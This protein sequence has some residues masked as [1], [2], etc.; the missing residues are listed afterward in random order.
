MCSQGGF[1]YH[2]GLNWDFQINIHITHSS[3]ANEINIYNILYFV[4]RYI[5]MD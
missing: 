4:N 5:Y 1:K 2:L 3:D